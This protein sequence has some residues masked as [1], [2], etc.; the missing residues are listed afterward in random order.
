MITFINI[1]QF[2]LV[3]FK[4]LFIWV[5]VSYNSRPSRKNPPIAPIVFKYIIFKNFKKQILKNLI[6]DGNKD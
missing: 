3:I 1:P 6:I 4:T 5:F 2:F